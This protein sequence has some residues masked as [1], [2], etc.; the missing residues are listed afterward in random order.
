MTAAQQAAL[1]EAQEQGR[2]FGV[3][4]ESRMGVG[5]LYIYGLPGGTV[6]VDEAGVGSW[7]RA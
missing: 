3:A 5:G 6:V 7:E 2:F 1:A 4:V